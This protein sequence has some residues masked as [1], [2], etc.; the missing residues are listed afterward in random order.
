MAYCDRCD[1]ELPEEPEA[2]SIFDE[3]D[4]TSHLC[5]RCERIERTQEHYE[6]N[7][8]QMPRCSDIG[9]DWECSEDDYQDCHCAR[10]G[11]KAVFPG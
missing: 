9:H 2:V 6:A 1:R 7:V 4:Y 11:K 3:T 5:Q 8:V 10:C